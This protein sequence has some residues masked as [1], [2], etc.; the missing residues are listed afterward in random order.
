LEINNDFLEFSEIKIGDLLETKYN[1]GKLLI[2]KIY[3]VVDLKSTQENSRWG[4]II[5]TNYIK[6]EG[7]RG[8]INYRRHSFKR[9]DQ[10]VVRDIQLSSLLDNE[11]VSFAVDYGKIINQVTNKDI[12][13]LKNLAKA[14]A[15]ENRH[16]LSVVDW[17][18]KKTG[19]GLGISKSDYDKFLN[20]P[21]KDILD[22]VY[23]KELR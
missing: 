2:G 7:Q 20:L 8:F 1:R 3:R 12:V 11:K 9:A 18:C 5:T 4:T 17:V 16:E 21:L 22:I 13:L 6:F 14:I 15:D 23:K 19:K 10:S